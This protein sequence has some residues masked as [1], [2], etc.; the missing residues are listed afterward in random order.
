MYVYVQFRRDDDDGD[1]CRWSISVEFTRIFYLINAAN[2]GKT[3]IRVVSEDTDVFVLTG[4]WV[5]HYL[6]D[7]WE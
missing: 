5:Y 7:E 6:D 1:L 3:M 4:H 2:S